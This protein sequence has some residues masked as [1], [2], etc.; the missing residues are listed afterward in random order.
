MSRENLRGREVLKSTVALRGTKV[1]RGRAL[2]GVKGGAGYRWNLNPAPGKA[3]TPDMLQTN[4][5][6][7]NAMHCIAF[8][9]HYTAIH[10]L[11]CNLVQ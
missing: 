2:G 6:H 8:D 11:Q 7:F 9:I 5:M 3:Q 10:L 4:A 1:L